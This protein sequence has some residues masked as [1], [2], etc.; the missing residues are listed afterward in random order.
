LDSLLQRHFGKEHSDSLREA[1]NYANDLVSLQRFE[2][3]KSLLRKTI[4]VALRVLGDSHDLT[5]RMPWIYAEALQKGGAGTLDDVREAVETLENTERTA[6]RVLGGA[7]PIAEV[8]EQSLRRARAAL[9]ARE[10]ETA[11]A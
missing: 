9:A 5:L 8:I 11:A 2:E 7:H 1:N 10:E 3:A 6:R 4:P